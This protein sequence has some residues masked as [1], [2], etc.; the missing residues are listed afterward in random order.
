MES[1]IDKIKASVDGNTKVKTTRI[2]W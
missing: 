2:S 1:E